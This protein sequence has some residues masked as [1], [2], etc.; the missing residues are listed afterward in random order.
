MKIQYFDNTATNIPTYSIIKVH[1]LDY[2]TTT[3][4]V[5]SIINEYFKNW[6]NKN[7]SRGGR[8]KRFAN[9]ALNSMKFCIGEMLERFKHIQLIN[10]DIKKRQEK[11][12]IHD[13]KNQIDESTLVNGRRRTNDGVFCSY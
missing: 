1:N 6:R 11:I 10:Y 7:L 12:S 3:I 5:Y 9:C 2:T 13:A 8:I 4:P